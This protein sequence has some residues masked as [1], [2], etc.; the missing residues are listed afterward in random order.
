MQ[1]MVVWLNLMSNVMGHGMCV[2]DKVVAD[3][4]AAYGNAHYA[5]EYKHWVE[6]CGEDL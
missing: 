3:Y 2:D 5:D 1:W 6:P 4:W